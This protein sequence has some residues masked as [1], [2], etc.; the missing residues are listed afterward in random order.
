MKN[1]ELIKL[2]QGWR[3]CPWC[4][5]KLSREIETDEMSPRLCQNLYCDNYKRIKIT[6]DKI[7]IN[8]HW[9]DE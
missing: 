9:R 7:V 5:I 6:P 4:G 3:Y 1:N 8:R 2:I